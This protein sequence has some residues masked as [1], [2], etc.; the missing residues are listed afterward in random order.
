MTHQDHRSDPRPRANPCPRPP[1]RLELLD[2][3]H[4]AG[5]ATATECSRRLGESV[6]SCSF[7]LRMLG[8][9]GYIEPA[10]RRGREKP[11]RV[12]HGTP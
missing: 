10:E 1:T 11:W 12:P 5:E 2:F 9:Y 8:K 4:E 7:H 3:L 6:A